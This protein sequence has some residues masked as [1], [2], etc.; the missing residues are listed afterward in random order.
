MENHHQSEFL[1][2]INYELQ[3]Q[4][5][6]VLLHSDPPPPLLGSFQSLELGLVCFVEDLP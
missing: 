1:I 3:H 5:S 6:L 4:V 2:A